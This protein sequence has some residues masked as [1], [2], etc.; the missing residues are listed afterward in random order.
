M[1]LRVCGIE[2]CRAEGEGRAKDEFRLGFVLSGKENGRLWH[3]AGLLGPRL[4]GRDEQ[5][6]LGAF[7]VRR[8][9]AGRAI[10]STSLRPVSP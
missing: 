9:G 7:S 10:P 8:L 6:K 4:L 2:T 3:N 1:E 5:A